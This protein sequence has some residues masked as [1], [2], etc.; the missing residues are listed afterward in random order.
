[1]P[2]RQARL[3]AHVMCWACADISHGGLIVVNFYR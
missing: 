1:M 2:H 3:M